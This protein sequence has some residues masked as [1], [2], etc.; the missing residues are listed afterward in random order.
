VELQR[1]HSF[2]AI[3]RQPIELQA[4]HSIALLNFYI[5]RLFLT[6]QN[7]RKYFESHCLTREISTVGPDTRLPDEWPRFCGS[8]HPVVRDLSLPQ[9]VQAGFGAEP[10]PHSA[11]VEGCFPDD[12]VTSGRNSFTLHS[13]LVPRLRMTGTMP[14]L[15]LMCLWCEY[16]QLFILYI[17]SVSVHRQ[18]L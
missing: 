12:N 4:S 17:F 10:F 13:Q 8:I 6:R 18:R 5:G 15:P 2:P 16:G 1:S 14:P 3:W 11:D 9:S 7:W